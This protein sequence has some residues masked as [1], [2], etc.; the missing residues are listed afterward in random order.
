MTRIP[1]E[2]E[3]SLFQT[4]TTT[5]FPNRK[6][7]ASLSSVSVPRRKSIVKTDYIIPRF[8]IV[9]PEFRGFVLSCGADRYNNIVWKCVDMDK[10]CHTCFQGARSCLDPLP[11][12]HPGR[13]S[14]RCTSVF[15][16][17]THERIQVAFLTGARQ[18]CP[19]VPSD[20]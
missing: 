10:A 17:R 5:F 20:H 6:L 2:K 1:T 16:Q 7:L 3:K 12:H 18:K 19:Y 8:D 9:G 13:L 14:R 11:G 15:N 4:V